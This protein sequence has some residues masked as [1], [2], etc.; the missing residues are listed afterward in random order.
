[1]AGAQGWRCGTRPYW[2]GRSEG[3]SDEE[4]LDNIRTAIHEY[5]SVVAS[6]IAGADV[7]EVEAAV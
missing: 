2:C 6:Q 1:V 7:R 4:A 5:L 3:S